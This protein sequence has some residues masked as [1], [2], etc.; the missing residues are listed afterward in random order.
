[1]KR[2][3]FEELELLGAIGNP[4]PPEP[5]PSSVT[6]EAAEPEVPLIDARGPQMIELC[7]RAVMALETIAGQISDLKMVFEGIRDTWASDRSDEDEESE[8]AAATDED[9]CVESF[10]EDLPE[11]AEEVKIEVQ[12]LEAEEVV[13][14]VEV[15]LAENAAP[16][17]KESH[18]FSLIE[19]ALLGMKNEPNVRPQ[20]FEPDPEDDEDYDHPH[21]VHQESRSP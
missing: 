14:E 8:E 16:E 7:D 19:D 20:L 1:M 15:P 11:E 6:I 9:F 13:E 10:V 18:T 17:P 21:S 12:E 5:V 2:S 3:V 4:P